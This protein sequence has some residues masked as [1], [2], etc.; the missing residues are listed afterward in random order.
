M[1]AT[2]RPSALAETRQAV[3]RTFSGDPRVKLV[4]GGCEDEGSARSNRSIAAA[5]GEYI[6]FL[7]VGD[8]LSDD[9]LFNVLRTLQARRYRL[10]YSDED[11]VS[12]DASGRRSFHSPYF[13]PDFDWDLL[14]GQNYLRRL[15]VVDTA[16]VRKIGGFRREYVGA[17]EYDLVLRCLE[18]IKPEPSGPC[19]SRHISLAHGGRGQL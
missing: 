8:Q 6:C 11:R 13:K 5:T 14:I 17:H 12:V 15:L 9:A 2:T 4:P 1:Y 7:D 10:L 19:L 18:N 16:L 3:D